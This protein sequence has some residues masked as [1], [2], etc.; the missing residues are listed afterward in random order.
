MGKFQA[1]QNTQWGQPKNAREAGR[2]DRP[3]RVLIIG[4]GF[5][6][7][8]G[9]PT[10]Y[11][12]FLWF[13]ELFREIGQKS[14]HD[15]KGITEAM[16]AAAKELLK[17]ETDTSEQK[18]KLAVIPLF[19]GAVARTLHSPRK[20][21]EL[22]AEGGVWDEFRQ[23]TDRN[24]WIRYFQEQLAEMKSMHKINW[25]DFETEIAEVLRQLTLLPEDTELR[26]AVIQLKAKDE[27]FYYLIKN[28]YP[29]LYRLY[30][31]WYKLTQDS[32]DKEIAALGSFILTA[33]KMAD[34]KSFVEG[35]AEHLER[36]TRAL[37]L[38]LSA[39][40]RNIPVQKRYRMIEEIRP[41]YVLS[42]NYTDTFERLYLQETDQTD[43]CYIHGKAE[44]AHSTE[45]C[46]MVLG[47][48]ET[49]QKSE[50]P[51]EEEPALLVFKKYYQRIFKNTDSQYLDWLRRLSKS[52]QADR[53]ADDVQLEVFVFGHSL[54]VT[55]QE[56][57]RSFIY[58]AKCSTT[59]YYHIRPVMG[60]QIQNLLRIIGQ[61]DMI[62]MSGGSERKIR[63][64][65]QNEA[66]A[67]AERRAAEQEATA[68]SPV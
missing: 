30:D 7:A 22:S 44:T 36:L 19:A 29:K 54:D 64:I 25:I 56:V 27:P 33:T 45:T 47:T 17:N 49:L 66:E 63:F 13:C 50:L 32:R 48:Q 10:T 59:V 51:E 20:K 65:D 67:E 68:D 2:S 15:E 5:D 35:L 37:E 6:L 16:Q 3:K 28:K 24:P 53:S 62:Q 57:L 42:F 39:V 14:I 38:F 11:G 18:R 60:T 31:Q 34:A 43:I 26:T 8:H 46:N 9:L 58:N 41:D 55:D 52:N 1:Y 40:V 61:K 12:D 23:M 21:T 4:N